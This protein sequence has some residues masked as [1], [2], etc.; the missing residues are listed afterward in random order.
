MKGDF[1]GDGCRY[2]GVGDESKDIIVSDEYT[3]GWNAALSAAAK[4]A[5]IKAQEIRAAN[6]YR[7]RISWQAIQS[8][9]WI[10]EIA[11]AIERLKEE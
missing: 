9:N 1:Y 7:G 2:R 8:A 4:V 10:E 3:K 11:A 5:T 6:T